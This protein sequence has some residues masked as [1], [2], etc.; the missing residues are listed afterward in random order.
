M[1]KNS[2]LGYRE[3]GIMKKI[4]I[5]QIGM[6]HE[7]ASAK[8][9]TLRQLTDYYE[10]V[11]I[12]DDLNY[13]APKYPG[14]D[15]E[16]Y[17][18]IRRMSEEELFNVKGLQA[19][20]VETANTEL[21]PT[22]IRCMKRG[23]HMHLDKPGGEIMEPFT[24]LIEGCKRKNLAIQLGYMYRV[25]PAIKFCFKAVREGWLGEIFEIHAIMNRFD[26]ENYRKYLSNFKG[27]AMFNFGCHLIDLVIS[28]MGRPENVV[29][30]QKST[31]DDGLN[32]NG[33]AVLEYS[34]ATA[35]VNS[36]ITEVDGFKYRRFIVC[37][38]KG[39]VEICPL[40]H[41]AD[42]Y[43]IEPLYARLTLLEDNS[44]YSAGT[45]KVN[46]G[47]MNGR[48]ENQLIELAHIINGE[49]SNPYTYEHELLVQ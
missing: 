16:C 21:V 22:A 26:D 45:H 24:E 42:L 17:A 39:T 34:R 25:N 47:V 48:Y 15:M 28:I 23:L 27:G 7:H 35:T 1:E 37:G 20:A 12:V 40:E 46:V 32:D 8:M 36:A 43:R 31:A 18:G 5:G 11:G 14:M 6:S 33:L 29:S 9:M 4:R 49:I 10:V 19:V 2:R 13:N 41:S 38:T 3:E 30:F 44:E